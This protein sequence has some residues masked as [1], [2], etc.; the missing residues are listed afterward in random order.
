MIL[1]GLDLIFMSNEACF[2][3]KNIFELTLNNKQL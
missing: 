1:R 3:E 2:K